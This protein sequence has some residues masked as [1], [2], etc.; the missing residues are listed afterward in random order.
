MASLEL[1]LGRHDERSA[2]LASQHRVG[3]GVI[4]ERLGRWVDV[5]L[6]TEA[7]RDVP[8][9]AIR[10]RQVS[11]LDIGIEDLV[12]AGLDRLGEVRVVIAAAGSK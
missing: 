12:V 10:A 11:F 6:P 7:I 9:V 2:V 8:E 3:L 4:D 1:N 5:K